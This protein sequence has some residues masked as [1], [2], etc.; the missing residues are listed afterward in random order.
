[1]N[2]KYL[3][4]LLFV[5]LLVPLNAFAL[6]PTILQ[7][8][9]YYHEN[10]NTSDNLFCVTDNSLTSCSTTQSAG[11]S[12]WV[13]GTDLS[14][15]TDIHAGNFSGTAV[16]YIIS[17]GKSGVTFYNRDLTVTAGIGSTPFPARG[18]NISNFSYSNLKIE[19]IDSTYNFD[20][21]S[22]CVTAS[23][24]YT[25]NI[26]KIIFS[27]KGETALNGGYYVKLGIG[28]AGNPNGL[29][30]QMSGQAWNN[31][32]FHFSVNN[33]F[34][35]NSFVSFTSGELPSQKLDDLNKTQDQTNQKIDDLNKN[36]NKTN[37]KLD[38]LNKNQ[39]KTNQKLDDTNK[40]LE[41]CRD[42]YNLLPYPYAETTTTKNG[43]TFTDNG[44]GSIT[45]NGTATENAYF[46]LQRNANYGKSN[47]NGAYD[48]TNGEYSITKTSIS[49]PYIHYNSTNKFI[50]INVPKGV[51]VNNLVFYPQIVKGKKT[52]KYEQYGKEICGSK[53]D[54][55]NDKL[56]DL[57]TTLSDDD[58]SKATND[59]NSFFSNFT[60]DTFGLTSIITAPL[61]LISSIT[62]SSCS[63]L[64][65]QVPFL[66][67]TTINLPCLSSIYNT[68]FGSFFTV[69]QTITFGIVAY[70]VCVRIFA[71]V[72][73]FKN[74]D[75]DKIE[76]LDL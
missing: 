58:S 16:I 23:N 3:F 57:N 8:A 73:D 62:S 20:T 45:I 53:I 52:R 36:Q 21:K 65:L 15:Y 34:G 13:T 4:L 48:S 68:Y 14:F 55:T 33:D 5:F 40:K 70:W 22:T 26:S 66:E 37:Q 17:T 44:D 76:V 29:F 46:Y 30:Y 72:K 71:L 50:T 61:N 31:Y 24:C 43:I 11:T 64:S 42:S 7:Q 51:T 63:S 54:D 38:D 9:Y 41:S 2:N 39:D 1:M 67:D 10:A 32:D 6:S 47:I 28:N 74:P 49:E 56:D 18:S 75:S 27:F 60:T 59:A 35:Y 69:Y 25:L 19:N 12:P